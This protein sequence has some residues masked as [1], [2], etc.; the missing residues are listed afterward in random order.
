MYEDSLR[1]IAF[2]FFA[3][4]AP[5]SLNNLRD[6][7]QMWHLYTNSESQNLME[8]DNWYIKNLLANPNKTKIH[9]AEHFDNSF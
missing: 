6:S 5:K 3:H 9:F 7:I 2:L 4:R 1:N 8:S